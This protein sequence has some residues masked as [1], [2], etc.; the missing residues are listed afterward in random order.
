[1]YFDVY[2]CLEFSQR[3]AFRTVQYELYHCLAT[4]M[5]HSNDRFVVIF[6]AATILAFVFVF[7]VIFFVV[8]L[9]NEL[10]NE[11]HVIIN[12]ITHPR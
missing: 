7:N 1:M 10:R 11:H 6:V 8:I 9:V 2:C 12:Y 4:E 5:Q 3:I